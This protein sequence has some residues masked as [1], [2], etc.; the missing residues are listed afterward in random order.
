M[1]QVPWELARPTGFYLLGLLVPLVVLYVL[2]I[3]RERRVVASTWLWRAAARDLS[4]A[5]PF[6]RLTPS[7]PLI[8]E[9]LAITALAVSLAN[10]F[11]RSSGLGAERLVVV[12]D[13][14]A[15]MG[16]REGPS[17]TRLSLARDAA[18]SVIRSARPGA[19][20][21]I[22]AAG[23]EPVLITPF[24]RDRARLENA[25]ARLSV[26][27]L[28]GRLGRS[29]SMAAAQLRQQGGGQIVLV[30]DAAV[31]DAEA[32]VSPAVP[33]RVIE[34]GEPH[35]NTAIVRADAVSSRDPVTGRQRV[36]ALALLRHEGKRP[37][38]LFV[39]LRQ[40]NVAEPLASRRLH[41]EPGERAPVALGFD[42]TPGDAGSGL[43]LELS[44]PDALTADDTA[45]VLIPL[46]R[47]LSVV[48]APKSASPWMERAL[49][50]DPEVELLKADLDALLS[51][52][53]PEDA[54]VIVEGACPDR[55]PGADLLILN[56][57]SGPCRGIQVG[58]PVEAPSVTSWEDGDPRLRFVDF[59]G[60]QIK[61]ARL[62]R[63]AGVGRAALLRA[64][65]GVLMADVSSPGRTGTLLSFDVGESNWPLRASFV[66]FVR[67]LVELSRSA[68]Q[69]ASAAAGRTG[70][71][72]A[73][74]VPLDVTEVTLQDSDEKEQSVL[75]RA[76]A[77]VIPARARV[78]FTHV[79]WQGAHPG[80][81]LFAASLFSEAES[82]I[83]PK[84]LPFSPPESGPA[85]AVARA[86]NLDFLLALLALVLI[87][88]DLL[89]TTRRP[90]PVRYKDSRP[91]SP[92]R[93]A[94]A[95]APS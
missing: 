48:L 5:H 35:D 91:L 71:P 34:V 43:T 85:R 33:L 94:S 73:L 18:L 1:P 52:Q 70:E 28:E 9:A 14:S 16:T 40:R 36:Q 32:L 37:R 68:R 41:L 20:I 58:P 64:R 72:T 4:A 84:K 46:G 30:T 13:A 23:R 54:L 3:R 55:L 10:P 69:G 19:E 21:M 47:A 45:H 38:D 49:R 93:P 60:I 86:T 44:P 92:E 79:S 7:L 75:A 62:I 53:V 78:G 50:A 80:S 83:T 27:E 95:R 29:L 51:A 61:S 25:V 12:V 77:A 88:L 22:L 42:A 39:T 67:N 90:R 24:E 66:L 15:S 56:P 74:R 63:A 89:V 6:R 31:A 17:S 87:A 57:P 81:T 8:L 65:A 76:G 82:R 59:E 2:K 11:L 26:Q